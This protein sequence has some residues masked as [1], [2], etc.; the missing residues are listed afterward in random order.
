MS[1]EHPILLLLTLTITFLVSL[2]LKRNCRFLRPTAKGLDI[3][4]ES[5]HEMRAG[6]RFILLYSSCEQLAKKSFHVRQL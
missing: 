1:F 2:E 4:A 3:A 6:S 5:I